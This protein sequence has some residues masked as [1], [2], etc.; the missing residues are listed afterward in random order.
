MPN[1]LQAFRPGGMS[2]PR[3]LRLAARPEPPGSRR[4]DVKDQGYT[5]VTNLWYSPTCKSNFAVTTVTITVTATT[6]PDAPST[7]EPCQIDTPRATARFAGLIPFPGALAGGPA[8]AGRGRCRAGRAR[9]PRAPGSGRRPGSRG[10]C[11][12]YRPGR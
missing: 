6:S 8:A 5:F 3:G 11:A 9:T 12:G 1:C 10:R 2:I 7:P 4:N